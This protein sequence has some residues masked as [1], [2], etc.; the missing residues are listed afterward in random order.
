MITLR[1]EIM[2]NI[3][4]T[5]LCLISISAFAENNCRD[6][7]VAGYSSLGIEISRDSFSK[8]TFE[9][10]NITT[11]QFNELSTAEQV[12]IYNSIKPVSVKVEETI[13]IINS[14]IN[15][16]V[17][18]VYEF[19]YIDDLAQMREARDLLRSCSGIN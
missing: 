6:A 13:S 11:E 1:G 3:C 7:V 4:L 17:G 8:Y 5:V 18:S 14:R 15:R 12:E 16:I 10:L 2:K 19:F 9:D